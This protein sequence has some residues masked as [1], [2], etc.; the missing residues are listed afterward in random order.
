MILHFEIPSKT[1][2]IGE[3]LALGGTASM[4]LATEPCFI[5]RTT[6][7]SSEFHHEKNK[8]GDGEHFPIKTAGDLP[9]GFHPDSPA[10]QLYKQMKQKVG[11]SIDDPYGGGGGFGRSTAEYLSVFVYE[12][13]LKTKDSTR[14]ICE[15]GEIRKLILS[16]LKNFINTYQSCVFDY[17]PS[18]AD[19]VAQVCGGLCWYD[20][21]NFSC[22]KLAWPFPGYEIYIFNTGYKQKTHEHIRRDVQDKNLKLLIPTLVSARTSLEQASLKI[23]CQ[24]LN[25]YY[26]ILGGLGLSD[27]KVRADVSKL[28]EQPE[29]LAAKACG[30][31]GMDT[32]LVVARLSD[33][34]KIKALGE[35]QGFSLISRL[36]RSHSGVRC[37]HPV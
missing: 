11:Y 8:K 3:Y 4:V 1:F 18:G 2:V 16:D 13:V 24:S 29:I 34:D 7:S 27:H 22:E 28:R 6:G 37:S 12:L 20:G 30:A 21:M 31:M 26:D 19:L 32:V 10:G 14:G 15:K 17:K 33:G 23:F 25:H 35:D 36:S 9:A 5:I